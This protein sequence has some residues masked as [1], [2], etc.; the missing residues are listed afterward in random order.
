[1]KLKP[2]TS[3]EVEKDEAQNQLGRNKMDLVP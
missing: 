3:S 2:I 1:M